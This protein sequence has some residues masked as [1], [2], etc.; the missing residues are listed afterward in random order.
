MIAPEDPRLAR[1]LEEYAAA[2]EVGRA[3]D[4]RAFLERHPDIAAALAECLDG[5]EFV[6]QAAPRLSRPDA[7]RAA[8]PPEV[9]AG[10]PLGDFRIVRE[11]GRGGMGVVYLAVQTSLGR[12]VALKVL[13]SA[14]AMDPR[15]LQR[16]RTEAHAAA[17]LHH[18]NIVPVHG[19]GCERGVHYYAMQLIEGQTLAD[20]LRGLRRQAGLDAP[21]ST[22]ADPPDSRNEAAATRA[23]AGLTTERSGRGPE[24]FR[25]A[26][27]LGVQAAEALAHAHEMGVVHRDV[28]PGN[29]LVDERGKLWVTDFGLAH[30]RDQPGL[31]LTG[32][33]LG[34]LR[35][36]SPEQALGRREAVDH[37]TDVYS[38]GVTLYELV[39]LHPACPGPGRQEVL[40]QIER[41]EP[42]RPRLLDPAVPAE[43]ETVVLKAA[44]KELAERYGSAQEL[45]DD[46]QRFLKDEPIRARRPT[47]VQRS[48][49]WARRHRPVLTAA[50]GSAFVVLALAVALLAVQNTRLEQAKRDLAEQFDQ[51][52]QARDELAQT[53]Y[54]RVVQQ[55][56]REVQNGNVPVA[57]KLLDKYPAALRNWE[58]HYVK[59]RCHAR[60]PGFDGHKG[61][62]CA[63]SFSRDDRH[64][65]SAGEDG[66]VRVWDVRSGREVAALRGHG[67]A[68]RAVAFGPN[69]RLASAGDDHLV[70][71]WDVAARQERFTLRGHAGAC[72]GVAFS[73][74]GALLA[75]ASDDRTARVWDAA[76]GRERFR[77][78]G[79][80]DAVRGVAFAPDGR[81]LATASWDRSV[82]VWDVATGAGRRGALVHTANLNCVAFSPDG[83]HLAAG[84][85]DWELIV[86]EVATGRAVLDGW[87]HAGGVQGVTFAADGRRLASASSD[88][89]VK[90]WDVR[91]G[92]EAIWLPHAGRV[93]GVAFSHDGWRL[94][95]AG[96]DGALKVWDGT[97]WPSAAA[98]PPDE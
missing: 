37:R 36:M 12:R 97:P 51:V 20:V 61:R 71:V 85:G 44:A 80:G 10:A 39:T 46:L 16:F 63:V 25:A 68:V 41:E 74:D 50:L 53:R 93:N 81:S 2:L 95:S 21:E 70:K 56:H 22:S 92:Q 38:L 4:R 11:I 30:L 27:R 33:V 75:T 14:A 83:K 64:L 98:E 79:H 1:A 87:G 52:E 8:G 7:D 60:Q 88:W 5:L 19:V 65:A 40:R 94:A 67:G 18:T 9:A 69:G 15:Q 49:K 6:H 82:R 34:T 24:F 54:L 47:L 89:S 76:T 66:T 43:L 58:W 32:D 29:L 91:T 48:R 77:L 42:R 23:A 62:V 55:A 28:K 13:P 59:R 78:E 26:A 3:P 90:V 35:Y 86:W 96:E 17:Q 31:T 72:R 45:A 73:P 84:A 57:L